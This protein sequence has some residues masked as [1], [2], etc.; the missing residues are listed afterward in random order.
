MVQAPPWWTM[1]P[2]SAGLLFQRTLTS[3]F[4]LR[5]AIARNGTRTRRLPTIPP[6]RQPSSRRASDRTGSAGQIHD[7]APQACDDRGQSLHQAG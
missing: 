1:S 7:G 6:P 2:N 5:R 4:G 3:L